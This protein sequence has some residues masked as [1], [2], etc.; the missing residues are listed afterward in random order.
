MVVTTDARKSPYCERA[1]DAVEANGWGFLEG[2][3]PDADDFASW[4]AEQAVHAPVAGNVVLAFSIP[5]GAVGF[6][7][8]VAL[9]ADVP[10]ASA[11]RHQ[12]ARDRYI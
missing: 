12:N 6:R 1:A 4:P 3:L 2:V 7:A 5:E 8:G 11:V 9:G 10:I